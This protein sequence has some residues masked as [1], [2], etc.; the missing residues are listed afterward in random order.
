MSGPGDDPGS[1]LKRLIRH[2]V[3][4]SGGNNDIFLKHYRSGLALL[5]SMQQQNKR[6]D[7]SRIGNKIVKQ[8]IREGR[9]QE[10]VRVTELLTTLRQS[11]Q[12]ILRNLPAVLTF[13]LSMGDRRS[14]P[15]F[16]VALR[17]EANIAYSAQ[18]SEVSER[19]DAFSTPKPY[20]NPSLPNGVGSVSTIHPVY[21]SNNQYHHNSTSR[22]RSSNNIDTM[23]HPPIPP[24]PRSRPN[25]AMMNG[26]MAA[27]QIDG[28]P[29]RLHPSQSH[30]N[31][32]AMGRTPMA[33]SASLH[34]AVE[35]QLV[36][37][38]I[39]VFQGIEGKLIRRDPGSLKYYISRDTQISCGQASL[40]LKLCELGWMFHQIEQF[41]EKE[42][43]EKEYGLVGQS[44]VTALREELTE[45]Y[46]LLSVLEKE[47]RE[48]EMSL[49]QLSVWAVEPLKRFQLLVSLVTVAGRARGGALA[50]CIYSF[51][52]QG[53]PVLK[54]CVCTLLTAA[55]RPVYTMLMRWIL[56]GSLEDPHQEFFIASQPG[57]QGEA[58]WHHKYFIRKSMI[59]RFISLAWSKK[60]L[61]TGKSINFLRSVCLD[62]SPIL[63]RHKIIARLEE[64]DPASLFSLDVDS[65]L[66]EVA[67]DAFKQMG[68]HVLDIMFNKFNFMSHLAALRKYL[69]LGQGDIMRYLL[70][71]LD[72]ELSQ[73][74]IQ[75][76]PHNLAG[77]LETA[78]RATNT[79]YEDADILERLDVR[80]L[81]IQ[82]GDSGWDVF[83]L[84][85][86]VS[87][88]IGVVFTP[89]TMTRYLM[90]FNT[91]WRA[92]RMEWV[93]S[94]TWKKLAYLHKM[95]NQLKEIRA[96]LHQAQ[97][98]NSEMVH[99]I[100]QMAYYITFEVMECGWD[101]LLKKI[102]TAE[103][104]EDVIQAHEE[105]LSSLVTRALLDEGT[106]EMRNQLRTVYDRI[107][108][109][110]NLLDKLYLDCVMEVESRHSHT[111]RLRAR[112]QAGDYGTTQTEENKE[113]DRRRQFVK[114]KLAAAK[115]NLRIISL[116]YQDMV[117]TFL[118]QL[119]CS[120]EQSLQG[121]SFRLDFNQHYKD[122]D[123][124]LSRPLTFSHRRMSVMNSSVT[125]TPRS[126]AD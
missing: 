12:H 75:L 23:F 109:Y 8:L 67:G 24:K 126:F 118:L 49:L 52:N 45:Y 26:N 20:S 60:I 115:A 100:H 66:L 104:L 43:S 93:L 47:V 87:G 124:R 15:V 61:S 76:Y 99:F 108:E 92:K 22:S 71:L 70:D 82:P 79:Q 58:L 95:S 42:G 73:P 57:I 89:D 10:A 90:L 97:L 122:K 34:S 38:L 31:L 36:K 17:S 53:D 107:L 16:N 39:Y 30:P 37:E 117:R 85:Y 111:S 121:L 44:F 106:L 33:P 86:K 55:C 119:T 103:S 7:D 27:D 112:T 14:D 81:E 9:Q 21:A 62:A 35:P 6:A 41:T 1:Q 69:L 102:D 96:V 110:Q 84:D 19:R 125:T 18:R 105:F 65:P 54:E 113:A 4:Q 11:S 114:T 32:N 68:Q 56:D 63:G 2:L 29:S 91:L 80:L 3:I 40:T 72:T 64:T 83:S 5:T 101:T 77:I 51:I 46:R 120:H 74:A 98:L 94:G 13:L 78:I 116:S 48:G 59:P 28:V 50:S 25:S 88:P 123:S